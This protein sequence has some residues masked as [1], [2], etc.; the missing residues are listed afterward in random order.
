[1]G[2]KYGDIIRI[3]SL[4][5]KIKIF[6][7]G[8]TSSTL[9]GMEN[10]NL[11]NY[12]IIEPFIL[13]LKEEYPNS[14]IVTSIQMSDDF[15][16]KYNIV[17]KRE[18]RFWTYG[19]ETAKSTMVD[20]IRVSVWFILKKIL[21]VNAR[22]IIHDS[23]LLEEIS[24]S[25]LIID[26]S[27]DIFGDNSS[28]NNFLEDCA[29]ILFAKIL[30]KPVAMIAGSPGPFKERWRKILAKFIFNRVDL[31]TNRE[32]VSTRLL[33]ELGVIPER[34]KTTACPAFLF[35]P[36]KREEI[37]QILADEKISLSDEKPLVGLIICGWNMPLTPNYKTP[38]EEWELRPFA[39]LIEYL[40]EKLQV[41]VF[42]M[43][44]QN[45]IDQ[46]G[47]VVR[48]T[49]HA[50]IFQLFEVLKNKNYEDNL[51]NLQGIYDARTS[52]AIIGC[53]DMLISGRIHGAVGGLSQ[54]I[55]TVIID[56][57][58]QPKA[59]KL[60]GF[61]QLVGI[62]QYIC[63]PKNAEDMIEKASKMWKARAEIKKM[64]ECK[65][66]QIKNEARG[67]F[68]FLHQCK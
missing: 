39:Q 54:C 46:A 29:E 20:F 53:F 28:Y 1:V 14:E 36:R 18:R 44:H 23:I 68:V 17:S 25:D 8:L 15:C 49:D 40:I 63:D 65:I 24:G 19:K 6:I 4:V 55:P 34:I 5:N 12:A 52:K 64:L 38:R 2:K 21:R 59:H 43:S 10:Q 35:Q 13:C 58:H 3:L 11:G 60:K 16:Q 41:R 22:C 7:L 56:Y 57:G 45:D 33:I 67:N 48:G 9:G 42:L 51:L 62:E 26:F 61:A 30:G 32:P 47:N 27:G 31:I 50:I 37:S 66:P